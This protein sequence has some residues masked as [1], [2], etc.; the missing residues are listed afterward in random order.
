LELVV[1]EA[2]SVIT[3]EVLETTAFLLVQLQ[4]AVVAVAEPLHE[5]EAEMEPLTFP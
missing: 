4:T 5:V 3:Q 2:Q 1:R